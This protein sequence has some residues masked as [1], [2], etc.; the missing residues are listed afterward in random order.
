MCSESLQAAPVHPAVPSL[1]SALWGTLLH[2]AAKAP[3]AWRGREWGFAAVAP[4]GF[5]LFGMLWVK[6]ERSKGKQ[7]GSRTRRGCILLKRLSKDAMEKEQCRMLSTTGLCQVGEM[8][9]QLCMD[10]KTSRSPSHWEGP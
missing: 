5:C 10:G 7:G 4:R 8:A 1:C 9:Q 6:G 2:L 3:V